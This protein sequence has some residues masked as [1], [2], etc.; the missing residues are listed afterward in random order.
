MPVIH[1]IYE[2]NVFPRML[3]TWAA[4]GGENLQV[5][6]ACDDGDHDACTGIAILG[7][8]ITDDN[9]SHYD[10]VPCQCPHQHQHHGPGV[11]GW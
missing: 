3:A 4:A 5:S 8:H 2:S 9:G 11:A 7:L 1:G 10:G 6:Q